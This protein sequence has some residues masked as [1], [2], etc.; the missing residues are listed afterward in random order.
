MKTSSRVE[1]TGNCVAPQGSTAEQPT[2]AVTDAERTD[3]LGLSIDMLDVDRLREWARLLLVYG[4]DISNWG[5][6]PFVAGKMQTIATGMEK[7][8][9][10]VGQ[11]RSQRSDLL[12]ALKRVLAGFE[13]NAFCR[14]IDGDGSSDWAIKFFPHLKALAD[15]TVAIEK[16][17]GH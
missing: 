13:A 16:A 9:R 1:P 12:D 8:I 6:L 14:N 4:P 15:A 7:A 5:G 2:G 3:D 11:L 17:E 10:E